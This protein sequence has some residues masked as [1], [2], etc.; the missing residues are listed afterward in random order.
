MKTHDFRES[1]KVGQKGEELIK[2]YLRQNTKIQDIQDVSNNPTYQKDDIDL[3]VT[4]TNGKTGTIEVKT[5]R[6]TSGNIFYETVSNKEYGV[7]GC[8]VKSKA[9]F[10][11]YYFT[12]TRELYIMDFAKYKNWFDNNIHNFRKKEL[13]NIDRKRTSTYT[14]IGYTIP[15]SYLEENFTSYRK[16]II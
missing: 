7:P 3:V 11:F 14:S 13:K 9:D 12:E 1:I 2:N 10:L 16:E 8:M 6:Y 15:K 5:D 4:F